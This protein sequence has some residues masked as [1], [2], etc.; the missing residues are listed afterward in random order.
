MLNDKEINMSRVLVPN[1]GIVSIGSCRFR[2][3]YH[4]NTLASFEEGESGEQVSFVVSMHACINC[5]C[6]RYQQN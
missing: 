6:Y 3:D 4:M 2:F 1:Q 5:M